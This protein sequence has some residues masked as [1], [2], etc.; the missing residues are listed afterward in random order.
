MVLFLREEDTRRL[1]SMQDAIELVD[2]A[3]RAKARGE[4][5]NLPRVRAQAG[6][7]GLNV[8]VAAYP[9]A[10][11]MAVRSYSTGGPG[12]M[13]SVLLY[14][15]EDA[16]PVALVDVRWLS[17]ART[18]AATAVATRCLARRDARTAAFIGAGRV[19]SN[20]V[21]ALPLVR[22][23]RHIRCYAPTRE[24]AERLAAEAASQGVEARATATAAEAVEG[25]DVV[26][27]ATSS[28]AIAL[29]GAWLAR[30]MHVNAVGANWST[31]RELDARAVL[32][33]DLIAVDDVENAHG[34]CGDVLPL[35]DAGHLTWDRLHDLGAILNGTTPGRTSADQI[36]LFES[37][38]LGLEDVA[39][40]AAAYERARAAGL[41]QEL[42]FG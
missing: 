42:P 25:A 8:L 33:A 24:H 23:L 36:T 41:G 3:L 9:A 38:G 14:S 32:A 30:G 21:A 13:N 26:T 28:R 11:Y 39:V 10:G 22:E 5:S 1:V 7:T 34:E 15:T 31:N 6:K 4:A 29:E 19:A 40:V 35:I 27:V 17:Q 37:Q 20:H 16:R 18:A 2:A 12:A